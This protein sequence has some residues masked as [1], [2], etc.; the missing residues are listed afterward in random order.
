MMVQS[1]LPSALQVAGADQEARH[2]LDG[3]LRGGQSDAREL[4]PGE[5]LQPLERSAPGA[6]RACCRPWRGSHPRS[7][8]ACWRACRARIASPAGCRATREWSR[9]C[10]AAGAASRARSC[11]GVSP[12]RTKVRISICGRPSA[13]SSSRMPGERRLEVAVDVVRQRLQRRDVDDA[14]LIRRG[15]RWPD[16]SRTSSIDD[17]KKR[18]ERLARAG[19]GGDE[20]V[21]LRADRR[22][23][24]LPAPGV[25]ALKVRSNQLA[26]AGWKAAGMAQLKHS[27]TLRRS[28]AACRRAHTVAAA[29]RSPV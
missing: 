3:L 24:R 27:G 21:T 29:Q 17:G 18:G 23:R 8:C 13:P 6:R 12:V 25:G 11:C 4:A 20:H 10:A 15:R 19:R 26:T 7:R 9:R 22:P 1:A 2:V 16:R 28:V 14:G 5:R